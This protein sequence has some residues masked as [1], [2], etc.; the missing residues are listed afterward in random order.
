ML[1]AVAKK[2]FGTKNARVLKAMRPTIAR[3]AELEAS[4]KA[5]SDEQLRHVTVE[6]K[7]R[8]AKGETLDDVLP[9]AFA[10]C[11]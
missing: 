1:S 5:K 7:Q 2:I 10:A 3:I 4:M 6:L 11:R 9:E 8:L